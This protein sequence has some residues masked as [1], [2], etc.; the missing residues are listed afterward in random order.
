[1]ADP[2]IVLAACFWPVVM[3]FAVY[4]LGCFIRHNW[5]RRAR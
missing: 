3:A 2:L 4:G 1:M 5:P